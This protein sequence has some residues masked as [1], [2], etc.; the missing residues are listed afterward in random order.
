MTYKISLSC[1]YGFYYCLK[2][3]ICL[4]KLKNNIYYKQQLAIDYL[5]YRHTPSLHSTWPAKNVFMKICIGVLFPLLS[6]FYIVNSRSRMGRKLSIYVMY[7]LIYI[8]LI[9]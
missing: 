1:F 4:K 3:F 7:D 2:N 9:V 5:K 8:V 6:L